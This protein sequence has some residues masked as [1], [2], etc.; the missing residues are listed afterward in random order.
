MVL[1][2]IHALQNIPRVSQHRRLAVKRGL[3]GNDKHVQHAPAMSCLT[4]EKCVCDHD[5][6]LVNSGDVVAWQS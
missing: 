4:Y 5:R 1:L 2:Q 6:A 3:R